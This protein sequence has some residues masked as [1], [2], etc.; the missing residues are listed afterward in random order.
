MLEDLLD[1]LE[2]LPN[3]QTVQLKM[4]PEFDPP[5]RKLL[6]SWEPKEPLKSIKAL[7]TSYPGQQLAYHCP[8]LRTL[9]ALKGEFDH[10]ELGGLTRLL[11]KP[12]PSI[13]RLENVT[14]CSTWMPTGA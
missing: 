13:E 8:N 2:L 4:P 5:T 9:G 7:Y 3:V 11:K 10:I 1:A 12:L 6:S 14:W